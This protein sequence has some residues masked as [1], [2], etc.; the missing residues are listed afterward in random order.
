[1]TAYHDLDSPLEMRTD[2]AAAG[3]T[4]LPSAREITYAT[5]YT[6]LYAEFPTD[7]PKRSVQVSEAARRLAEAI[8]QD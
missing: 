6:D 5:A 8:Y 4:L 3:A 1:M 7:R 2:A